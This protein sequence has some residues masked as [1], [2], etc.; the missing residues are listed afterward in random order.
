VKLT[1]FPSDFILVASN[2]VDR[3]YKGESELKCIYLRGSLDDEEDLAHKWIISPRYKLREEGDAVRTNDFII[4]RNAQYKHLCLT[5]FPLSAETIHLMNNNTRDRT[6]DFEHLVGLDHTSAVVTRPGLQIMSLKTTLGTMEQDQEEQTGASDR[7]LICSSDCIR[8]FHRE[9]QGHLICR[10]DDDREIRSAT[11]PLGSVCRK[12]T[13]VKDSSHGIFVRPLAA[14]KPKIPQ[15]F[16]SAYS[17]LGVWQ[18]LLT[19]PATHS[20]VHGH[21]KYGMN[22]R[23][24][25]VLTG[26]FLSVRPLTPADSTVMKE[27]TYALHSSELVHNNKRKRKQSSSE[28]VAPEP[29]KR[30]PDPIDSR[31]V[32]P[33]IMSP[34]ISP[35]S[36][37]SPV[38][39]E[40]PIA[41]YRL[42]VKNIVG[43]GIKSSDW[44][45]SSPSVYLLLSFGTVTNGSSDVTAK[46]NFGSSKHSG[47][48]WQA[49]TKVCE[50]YFDLICVN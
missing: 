30:T 23:L 13:A 37:S 14:Q 41:S 39:L 46:M 49:K 33:L 12:Q 27:H 36:N 42:T 45:V 21:I 34:Q 25:H 3:G 20:T 32:S 44:G 8:I 5:S 43:K 40:L 4:L 35:M 47:R 10:V 29:V 18:I 2:T 38:K 22:I 16:P 26:Q 9:Y 1:H 31:S 24:R 7:S 11:T 50:V 17:C 28:K 19:S 6:A 15:D 48:H